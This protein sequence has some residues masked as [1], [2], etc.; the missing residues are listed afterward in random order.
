[1]KLARL[2]LYSAVPILLVSAIAKFIS[3]FG[4]GS[5][6]GTRDPVLG[7]SFRTLFFAAALLETV[8]ALLCYYVKPIWLATACLAWLA[9]TLAAYR[10]GLW[11]V[12]W[13]KPCNCL[14]SLTDALHIPASVVDILMKIVL[15]Y[16]LVGSYASLFWFWRVHCLM[17]AQEPAT[18]SS[19]V[20]RNEIKA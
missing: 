7:I 15:A 3:G 8:I 4:H 5:V 12:G 20:S 14:G 18:S 11:L 2:F 9:T 17:A 6:L 10:F 19:C 1:M 13:H 16:L